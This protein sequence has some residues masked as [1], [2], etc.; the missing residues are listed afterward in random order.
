MRF[1]YQRLVFAAIALAAAGLFAST[2]SEAY[3]VPAFGGDVSTVFTPRIFL[4]LV[5]IFSLILLVT[6]RTGE[7]SEKRPGREEM[8]RL[9]TVSGVALVVAFVLPQAGFV[10][11]AVPGMFLF[12]LL[13]GYRRLL[14]L[15]L[16][17]VLGPLVVWFLFNDLLELPLPPTD[18]LGLI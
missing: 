15:G 1:S 10:G 11:A 8:L 7:G 5:L 13:F 9:F 14:T 6:A 3:D 2:Y 18:W 12:C 16:T 17:A 4:A